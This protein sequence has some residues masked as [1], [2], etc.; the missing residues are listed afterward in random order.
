MRRIR[1]KKRVNI[2]TKAVIFTFSVFCAVTIISQQLEFNELNEMRLGL[3]RQIS[4][5]KLQIEE[6]ET[7]LAR[8]FDSEYIAKIARSKLKYHMPEEIIFY[9]DLIR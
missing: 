5:T 3:Q 4:D 2:F 9:N 7:D 8:P 6:L 1:T